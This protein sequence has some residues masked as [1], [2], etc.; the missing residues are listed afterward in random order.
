MSDNFKFDIELR[1][2]ACD[3]FVNNSRSVTGLSY[4]VINIQ[5]GTN[6]TFGP[7]RAETRMSNL[8]RFRHETQVLVTLLEKRD[9]KCV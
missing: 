9:A 8:A 6:R 7:V 3:C 1:I 2:G 5:E 4:R